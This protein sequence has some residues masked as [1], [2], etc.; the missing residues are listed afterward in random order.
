MEFSGRYLHILYTAGPGCRSS[1]FCWRLLILYHELRYNQ[2]VCKVICGPIGFKLGMWTFMKK[3]NVYCEFA[4]EIL[5]LKI[6]I[7]QMKNGGSR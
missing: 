7:S 1:L 3:V 4:L 2:N 6:F 5:C